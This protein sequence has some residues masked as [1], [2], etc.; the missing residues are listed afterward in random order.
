MIVIGLNS[1]KRSLLLDML[2]AKYTSLEPCGDFK[3]IY[4]KL[5]VQKQDVHALLDCQSNH[6][7]AEQS[8]LGA[9]NEKE[10]LYVHSTQ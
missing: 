9:K 2:L 7:L 8:F 3:K 5:S 1:W 10:Y 6:S 4:F